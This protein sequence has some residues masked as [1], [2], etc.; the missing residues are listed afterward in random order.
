MPA[1]LTA[2]FKAVFE[3]VLLVTGVLQ[4]CASEWTMHM[5]NMGEAVCPARL[6]LKCVQIPATEQDTELQH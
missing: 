3:C 2:R 6:G 1:C 5:L 4:I